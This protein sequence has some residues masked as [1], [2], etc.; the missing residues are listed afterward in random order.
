MTD[1]KRF[2]EKAMSVFDQNLNLTTGAQMQYFAELLSQFMEV[3]GPS[4][5]L[6]RRL[7]DI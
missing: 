4:Q 2:A 5:S 1:P 6:Q 7:A 3:T